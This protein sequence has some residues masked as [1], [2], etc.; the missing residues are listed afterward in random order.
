ML[1]N[2]F[3]PT[4]SLLLIKTLLLDQYHIIIMAVFVKTND[5]TSC[6]NYDLK[7]HKFCNQMQKSTKKVANVKNWLKKSLT[8]THNNSTK[9]DKITKFLKIFRLLN[10]K[11]R[12]YYLYYKINLLD[13][14]NCILAIAVNWGGKV[15]NELWC[16][17]HLRWTFSN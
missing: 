12:G 10:E 9:M 3:G 1:I 6:Q 17:N 8:K 7:I 2:K 11:V 16:Y 15:I 5:L 4:I 14:R 13:K